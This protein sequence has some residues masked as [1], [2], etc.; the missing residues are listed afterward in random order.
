MRKFLKFYLFRKLF[1]A[2]LTL[3][4][5]SVSVVGI[6][7]YR[8][9]THTLKGSDYETSIRS[10]EQLDYLLGGMYESFCEAAYG[11][12]TLRESS[13][14]MRRNNVD[15]LEEYR[16]QQHLKVLTVA[17]SQL[18]DLGVANM[19]TD[20]YLSARKV[21][22]GVDWLL[23]CFEDRGP[24]MVKVIWSGDGD[25]SY[26]GRSGLNLV[27]MPTGGS[28]GRGI[29]V[30]NIAKD[31]LFDFY[32]RCRITQ[33]QY[34]LMMTE[35]G[36]LIGGTDIVSQSDLEPIREKIQSTQ[37]GQEGILLDGVPYW[38]TFCRSGIEGMSLVSVFPKTGL[39]NGVSHILWIYGICMLG[40]FAVYMLLSVYLSRMIYMPVQKLLRQWVTPDGSPQREK[41]N[42]LER[43]NSTFQLYDDIARRNQIEYYLEGA[44]DDVRFN[45]EIYNKTAREIAGKAFYRVVL[46]SLDDKEKIFQF[47][48]MGNLLNRIISQEL[49]DMCILNRS[50][51]KDHSV[52]LNVIGMDREDD[53]QEL[54]LALKGIQTVFYGDMN[55]NISISCGNVVT[56][57]SGLSR[58]YESAVY[59]LR[60]RLHLGKNII[61]D[62]E[63]RQ[64]NIRAGKYPEKAAKQVIT[65][66]MQNNRE[67]ME[68]ALND[69]TAE[70]GRY[71]ADSIL[72]FSNRLCQEI[73]E[74]L[75]EVNAPMSKAEVEGMAERFEACIA[76]EDISACLKE[77]CEEASASKYTQEE[78]DYKQACI[79]SINQYIQENYG[80][81]MLSVE[82]LASRAG[83][84][85][86][87]F[88]KVFY[89]YNKKS[90]TDYIVEVRMKAAARKLTESDDLIKDISEQVGIY[91]VNYFYSL[92]KKQY[93]KTPNQFRKE[94]RNHE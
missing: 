15:R 87:Y 69:F 73:Q 46:F 72:E 79:Q 56:G 43:I 11:V 91:N 57:L 18:N 78:T 86:G 67:Q 37:K 42:E 16:L 59:G 26:T 19:Q 12:L 80:N 53:N 44:R 21:Y 27:Y 71:E 94:N 6:V 48:E 14:F 52:L 61:Y 68:K 89:A 41:I 65:C 70:I 8:D 25:G 24:E 32:E 51:C 82:T 9:F 35:D 40:L 7:L 31:T 54:L 60:Q 83:M 22:F 92:F 84:S 36:T 34:L 30:G 20:R 50:I 3:N 81:A 58:S 5:L 77:F 55:T 63:A 76:M 74:R 28:L 39:D 47:Q 45:Q 88:G 1:L 93:G 90:C 66:I 4:I 13:S 33:E 85:A 23:P 75:T 2:F 49:G 64:Q 29:V 10:L 17:N 62:G 38:V